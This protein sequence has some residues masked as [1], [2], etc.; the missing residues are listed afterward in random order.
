MLGKRMSA[1]NQNGDGGS[2]PKSPKISV[3]RI[4]LHP[5]VTARTPFRRQ[6]GPVKKEDSSNRPHNPSRQTVTPPL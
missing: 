3:H 1:L 4:P 2:H 5:L 6:H